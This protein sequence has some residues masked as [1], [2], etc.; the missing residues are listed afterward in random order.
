MGWRIFAFNIIGLIFDDV[1]HNYI[2]VDTSNDFL[3]VVSTDQL[4]ARSLVSGVEE[5]DTSPE[6]SIVHLS[7]PY[8]YVD[9]RGA[10]PC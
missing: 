7:S 4:G 6:D 5:I 8:F 3:L 10:Y 2:T 9:P 1:C